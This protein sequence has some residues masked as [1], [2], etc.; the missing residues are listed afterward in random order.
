MD[1]EPVA[2]AVTQWTLCVVHCDIES[3]VLRTLTRSTQHGSWK[4]DIGQVY[5]LDTFITVANVKHVVEESE[6]ERTTQGIKSV[7]YYNDANND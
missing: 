2:L 1:L 5:C 7:Y 6:R 4:R 3:V